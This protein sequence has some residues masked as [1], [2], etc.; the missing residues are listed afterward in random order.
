MGRRGK[1]HDIAS[2]FFGALVATGVSELKASCG[3]E[4]S[5][6]WK[7]MN[8]I[9][10][11][12]SAQF[13]RTNFYVPVSLETRRLERDEA[14]VRE[15]G[16]DGPPPACARKFSGDR[17][18]EVA[19]KHELTERQVYSIIKF[20]RERRIASGNGKRGGGRA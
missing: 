20:M 9:A 4:E 5:T 8:A 10:E 19:A 13:A 1:S 15:C 14:I 16:E 2:A 7:V 18:R 6:G 3:I 11:A 12:M 17:L